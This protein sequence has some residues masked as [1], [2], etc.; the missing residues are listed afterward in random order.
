VA[1]LGS[2]VHEEY[3]RLVQQLY[4]NFYLWIAYIN[5]RIS[6]NEMPSKLS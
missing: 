5:S 2:A 4:L 1:Q 6:I 3:Q